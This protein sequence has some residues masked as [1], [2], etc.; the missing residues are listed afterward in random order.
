MFY[1]PSYQ[2]TLNLVA[3]S[4]AIRPPVLPNTTLGIDG[5]SNT[6]PLKVQYDVKAASRQQQ[7]EDRYNS[8]DANNT[9]DGLP[10]GAAIVNPSKASPNTGWL[11]DPLAGDWGL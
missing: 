10:G 7:I 9:G 2:Q 3:A 6:A 1:R 5:A 8:K 4:V 11:G